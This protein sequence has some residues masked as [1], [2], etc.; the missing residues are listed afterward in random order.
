MW[1]IA[2]CRRTL[3]GVIGP[4]KWVL[5]RLD[6]PEAELLH[7]RWWVVLLTA[8]ASS[9]LLFLA[10]MPQDLFEVRAAGAALGGVM[11]TAADPAA[12]LW[13]LIGCLGVW[14]L[15]DPF[16]LMRLLC[17][18]ASIATVA[19][20]VRLWT[21]AFGR[22]SV[23]AWAA[24]V[25]A[26]VPGV[27]F[28]SGRPSSATLML[29]LAASGCVLW[30]R[31]SA[32]CAVTG[33]AL[34]GVAGA[35]GS[36][37]AP[38][39]VL[40]LLAAVHL[41][42]ERGW[43]LVAVA[44]G[45]VAGLILVL[46]VMAASSDGA[47][48]VNGW[49]RT[50]TAVGTGAARMS[51]SGLGWVGV[52]GPSWTLLLLFPALWGWLVLGRRNRRLALWWTFLF[53]ATVL[54]LLMPALR[55]RPGAALPL[56]ALLSGPWVTG[57]V[58]LLRLRLG[59][60]L[61]AAVVVL[62]ALWTLPAVREQADRV[63]G[64]VAALTEAQRSASA[65]TIIYDEG[66]QPHVDLLRSAR[67]APV[68]MLTLSE[69]IDRL[70][71]KRNMRGAWVLV[72]SGPPPPRWIRP[73]F[74]PPQRFGWRPGDRGARLEPDQ[75][76]TWLAVDGALILDP[77]EPRRRQDGAVAVDADQP[78]KLMLQPTPAA[79]LIG[80][81]LGIEGGRARMRLAR[82]PDP[83]IRSRLGPG[84]HT[85]H[86]PSEELLSRPPP[87]SPAVVRLSRAK[88]GSGRVHLA[89]VWVDEAGGGAPQ[90]LTPQDQ[91][92]GRNGLVD[93]EGFYAVERL[94][95]PPGE[96]RWTQASAWLSLPAG[97]ERLVINLCA[98]RPQPAEVVLCS[99]AI[100]WQQEVTVGPVWRQV[101]VPMKRPLARLRLV[102]EVRNPFVP[103]RDLPDSG[104]KRELG[105]VVGEIQVR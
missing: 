101:E 47:P 89:R 54:W 95:S 25:F 56:V 74:G 29:F 53:A 23:A 5:Q 94:G 87:P 86:V 10:P 105:V 92:G 84:E 93:G 72:W 43:G 73:A 103:A 60:A 65:A 35:L 70:G 78:L 104:D 50:A 14:L 97:Q 33:S 90:R 63:V 13:Q 66:L 85:L 46:V 4:L 11:E 21:A 41:R 45:A 102:I 80:F 39:M 71:S 19:L 20:L 81:K 16:L 7:R 98:P 9:R 8:V 44:G 26:A 83:P 40:L 28:F 79:S 59:L 31:R 12:A 96:G 22:A 99:D 91:A 55:H 69:V 51:P 24:A 38:V 34:V 18:A 77:P 64:Q 6:A 48:V 82:W 32:L 27:W 17:T 30:L 67:R 62:A 15:G 42:R 68:A 37:W 1:A 49:A 3:C 52:F 58:R 2:H 88:G 75:K 100:G 76:P 61:A 36:E 57:L